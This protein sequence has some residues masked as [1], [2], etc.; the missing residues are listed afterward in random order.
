MQLNGINLVEERKTCD[1]VVTVV[2]GI[3]TDEFGEGKHGKTSVLKLLKLTLGEFFGLEVGLSGG[4]ISK[5]SLGVDNSD[6]SDDLD[7]SE[8]RNSIDGIKTIGDVS[9]R[10]SGGDISSPTPD[11]R[12]DV[13][14]DGKLGN[15]AVLE[16]SSAVLVELFLVNSAGKTERIPEAGRGDGSEFVGVLTDTE[17]GGTG[18]G[19]SRGK[20]SGGA[21]KKGGDSELHHG[22][23]VTDSTLRKE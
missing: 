15:T 7:P 14:D 8:E 18:L 11:F 4:E 5:V 3:V 10:D 2:S 13:S 19:G 16:L 23:Q 12:G 6:S 21:G 17:S 9:V 20:G 1:E 22:V